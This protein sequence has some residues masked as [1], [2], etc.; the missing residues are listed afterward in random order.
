MKRN[1][2]VLVV[3][4]KKEKKTKKKKKTEEGEKLSF[5]KSIFEKKT[6]KRC[7]LKCFFC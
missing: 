7:S 6:S 2:Q 3:L 5:E 1:L 4:V